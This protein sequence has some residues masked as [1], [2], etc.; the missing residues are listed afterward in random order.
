M[1]STAVLSPSPKA[2]DS[3]QRLT[4]A[5]TL[6]E[7]IRSLHRKRNEDLARIA[8]RLA[9][10]HHSRGFLSLGFASVQAYAKERLSWGA[11]KVKAL[12]ELQA[13]LGEQPLIGSAFEAGEVDWSKAVLA[14]RA[15][16]QE[17]EREAD[18]L[19]DAQELSSRELEAKVC[20]RTGSE[21]R[22][23][24]WFGL[25]AEDEGVVDEGLRALR[26]EGLDL[27]PGAALA[28]L[29]RRAL[30]GGSA[31]SS[32]Y[33]F[34]LSRCP[35][36]ERTTHSTGS[37]ELPV[38]PEVADRLLCDAEVQ[39][40]RRE[41]ARVTSTVPPSVKN[42]ILARSKG[43][44]E[45]PGCTHRGH[46]E[47]HHGRGRGGGHD[48]D[49]MYHFCAGHHVAP[50]EGAVRIQGSWSKGV[51]FLRADGSLIGV[52]GGPQAE[53][54]DAP[55]SLSDSG[56]SRDAP[57]V[58]EPALSRDSAGQ[59][60]PIAAEAC[61]DPLQE[62]ALALKVL[63]KLEFP[64]RQANSLLLGALTERPALRGA[65][66]EDLARAVLLRA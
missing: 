14:S 50:H 60:G 59:A 44:C 37:E 15:A 61:V 45:F 57:K 63:G 9:E 65:R 12:L 26:T 62:Q 33:R 25:T 64:A 21:P 32:S 3:V 11:A 34:L 36:C 43:C 23:G 6:D 30:Q 2:L 58:A 39:D 13:R 22:Q 7:E 8:R 49:V 46:L 24:R 28:E 56:D 29:I 31:G 35:D 40:T 27:E 48:P 38:P 51:R 54:R 42:Q 4:L 41:P 20:G 1:S 55:G 17:P 5:H 18:W 16:K 47:F 10:L 52:V 19:R 66:A 53:S